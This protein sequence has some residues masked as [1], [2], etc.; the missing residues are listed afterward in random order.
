[1]EGL[2]PW[3]GDLHN[4][5]MGREYVGLICIVASMICGA[6]VGIERER[7]DKPAGLRTVILIAVGSTMF[8]LVSLLLASDPKHPNADPARLAAQIIPGIG[9]LGAGAIIH[10]RGGGTVLGLTTGAT[11]WAVSAVG[12]MIGAGYVA[13][14]VCFTMI[15]FFTLDILHRVDWLLIGRCRRH[16]TLV[17][18]RTDGGKARP[19]I[20]EILDRYRVADRLVVHGEI[21]GEDRTVEFSS[22]T[23][24]R[25][26]RLIL[27]DLGDIAEVKAIH[28]G[29]TG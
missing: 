29:E 8:T 14:G 21:P 23:N 4:L 24:H 27:K 17:T 26:H 28:I 10:A 15:I 11:I 3:F 5:G 22:C 12:V 2:H 19:R 20:Q 18:Y 16:R 6:V 1:M 9:F 13:A 7:R 25:H